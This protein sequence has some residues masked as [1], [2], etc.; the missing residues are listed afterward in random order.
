[1]LRKLIAVLTVSFISVSI[2]RAETPASKAGVEKTAP[3]ALRDAGA[4][5]QPRAGSAAALLAQR[6]PSVDWSD[7]PFEDILK[8]VEDL[9]NGQVNVQAKTGPLGVEGVTLDKAVTLKLKN[10]TVAEILLEVEEQLLE[11]GDLRFIAE[12]NTLKFTTKQDIDKQL[13]TRVYDA[14]DIL[15]RIPNF[16]QE[17]PGIDLQ[18][19]KSSGSGGGGGGQSVFSGGSGGGKTQDDESG[20]QGEQKLEERLKKLQTL[21]EAQVEPESWKT[22]QGGGK[23]TI[24]VFQSSLIVKA[25]I[26]VHEQIAGRFAYG[27]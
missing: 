11:S 13:Y 6:V 22:P 21:I 10:K 20:T 2:A 3:E 16:G 14:T 25:T 24:S 18:K 9:G 15:T 8:W 26:E 17:A 27:E 12:G 7:T 23:N 19:T 4:A 1:M 5:A